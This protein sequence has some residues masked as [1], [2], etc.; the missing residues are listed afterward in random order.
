MYTW[1]FTCTGTCT[2]TS[3]LAIACVC[4]SFF[5]CWAPFHFQ[6]L[7]ALHFGRVQDSENNSDFIDVTDIFQSNNSCYYCI[8]SVQEQSE[9]MNIQIYLYFVVGILYYFTATVNPILYNLM[10]KQFRN[11]YIVQAKKIATLLYGSARRI[12]SLSVTD[13]RFLKLPSPKPIIKIN[14]DNRIDYTTGV[15]CPNSITSRSLQDLRLRKSPCMIPH[16]LQER[17]LR[18]GTEVEVSN[19][20]LKSSHNELVSYHF[21]KNLPTEQTDFKEIAETSQIHKDKTCSIDEIT[22]MQRS[23]PT[24][25]FNKKWTIVSTNGCY[26]PDTISS[27][28]K[29]SNPILYP[30]NNECDQN[31]I[32]S[33][34]SDRIFLPSPRTKQ[35]ESEVKTLYRSFDKYSNAISP[36]GSKL[37]TNNFVKCTYRSWSQISVSQCES[38]KL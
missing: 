12:N 33:V 8:Q 18:N 24:R 5:V 7:V 28:S 22:V 37:K 29:L 15:N 13:S 2:L 9:P 11:A 14:N 20:S 30:S 17:L 3:I 32:V 1:K 26:S 16:Y 25:Q 21:W 19:L 4:V 10:S 38:T 6:R 23:K 35:S 31:D 36:E 27:L 34:C